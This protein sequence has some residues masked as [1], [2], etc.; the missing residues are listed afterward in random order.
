[1]NKINIKFVMA[2][3][4]A[5]LLLLTIGCNKDDNPV[6]GTE[7]KLT[8]S[9]KLTEATINP[10]T[11]S[12]RVFNQTLLQ[13]AGVSMLLDVKENGTYTFTTSDS[14][15]QSTETGTWSVSG[16]NITITPDGDTGETLPFNLDGNTLTL[17]VAALEFGTDIFPAILK[18]TKQ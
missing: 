14:S 13:L 17:T 10:G 5:S 3:L 2:L 7:S 15:G 18:F 11:D 9:W 8:G 1:M 16:S 12:A 4:A 6:G